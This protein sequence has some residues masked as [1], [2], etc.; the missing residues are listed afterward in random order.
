MKPIYIAA[1]AQSRFGKLMDMTVPQIV[2]NAVG[3]AWRQ[4]NIDASAID[5]G[6]I[7]AAFECNS[8]I[9]MR[10]GLRRCRGWLREKRDAND[11]A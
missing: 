2:R 4:V 9:T 1:Y 10:L 5:V 8:E 7:A 3:D 11:L 6:A